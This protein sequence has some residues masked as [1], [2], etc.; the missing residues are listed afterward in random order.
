M[1]PNF[2]S[3]FRM[4]QLY[5]T[6][7]FRTI[8]KYAKEYAKEGYPLHT[9]VIN[10]NKFLQKLGIINNYSNYDKIQSQMC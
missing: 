5:G 3:I 1:Q 4:L 9:G 7:D 2:S 6:L 8:S 10:Q